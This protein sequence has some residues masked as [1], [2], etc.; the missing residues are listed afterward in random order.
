MAGLL[1]VDPKPWDGLHPDDFTPEK[2]K[3]N[4]RTRGGGW[5]EAH[6]LPMLHDA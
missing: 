4:N 5:E 3:E 6:E 2:T 1:T